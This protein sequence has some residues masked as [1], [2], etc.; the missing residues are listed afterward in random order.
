MADHLAVREP[1]AGPDAA[2]GKAPG[3]ATA[4]KEGGPLAL[5]LPLPS[6]P[7]FERNLTLWV[8]L[9]M[10]AGGLLG[11]YSPATSA[12]LADLQFYGINALVAACL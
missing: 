9:C 6:L 2:A 12:A 4:T 7:F 3:T 1:A 5:P 11:A 10:V 8:A